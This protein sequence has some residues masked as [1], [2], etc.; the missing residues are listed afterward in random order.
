MYLQQLMP[1]VILCAF[2]NLPCPRNFVL[3]FRLTLVSLSG[4]FL[5]PGALSLRPCGLPWTCLL[6]TSLLSPGAQKGS[7]QVR[8]GRKV[9]RFL[10]CQP[11]SLVFNC[12]NVRIKGANNTSLKKTGHRALMEWG[13]VSASCWRFQKLKAFTLKHHLVFSHLLSSLNLS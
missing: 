7:P 10:R 6:F 12:Q 3:S 11:F 1:S 4:P 5:C 9:L 2:H 13:Q 8:V